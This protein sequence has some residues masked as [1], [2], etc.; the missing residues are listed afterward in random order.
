MAFNKQRI[1][2]RSLLWALY[3][4]SLLSAGY[5]IIADLLKLFEGQAPK[6]WAIMLF[7]SIIGELIGSGIVGWRAVDKYYPKSTKRFLRRY[8][9]FSLIS[10][11]ASFGILFTPISTILLFWSIFAAGLTLY[12][13]QKVSARS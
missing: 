1:F 10:L 6:F 3:I 5:W 11:M 8:T 7:I 2:F 12:T 9:L 13:V 4:G